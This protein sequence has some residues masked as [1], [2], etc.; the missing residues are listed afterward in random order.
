MYLETG[1]QTLRAEPGRKCLRENPVRP[2]AGGL[3]ITFTI[4]PSPPRRC[5][6]GML[7]RPTAQR[8]AT[9]TPATPGCLVRQHHRSF[10]TITS[11]ETVSGCE[12]I[13]KTNFG[14]KIWTLTSVTTVL[15]H[16]VVSL[17]YFFPWHVWYLREN[18]LWPWGMSDGRST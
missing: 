5:P 9:R 16:A 15:Y 4:R 1:G 12:L 13:D 7:C 3:H 2:R 8:T 6:A 14:A 18:Q 17:P 10:T 11:N